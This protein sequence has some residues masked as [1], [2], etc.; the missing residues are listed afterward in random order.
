MKPSMIQHRVSD[1]M[2]FRA[3]RGALVSSALIMHALTMASTGLEARSCPNSD[4]MA[5]NFDWRMCEI[6]M[7]AQLLWRSTRQFQRSR[8]VCNPL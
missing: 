1:Q 5:S 2:V 4:C 3:T 7:S 6:L 8:G